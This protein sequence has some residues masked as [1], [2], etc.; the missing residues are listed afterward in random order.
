MT[1]FTVKQIRQSLSR[2]TSNDVIRAFTKRFIEEGQARTLLREIGIKDSEID[3]IINTAAYKR[4]WSLKEERIDAI[5]NLFK[6]GVYTEPQTRSALS[7]LNLPADHVSTLLQQWQLKAA[8]EKVA[9]W[10]ATQT[11][12]FLKKGLIT[13]ERARQEFHALGYDIEHISVYL[14][15]VKA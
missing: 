9:N 3:Y 2:F 13:P 1:E 11:L 12:T 6:K 5:E 10:T 15:S 8:V 14:A 7:G 4:E